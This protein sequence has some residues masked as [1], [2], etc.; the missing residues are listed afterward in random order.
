MNR[1][2]NC[3]NRPISIYSDARECLLVLSNEKG[4]RGIAF[5]WVCY[6]C[7]YML[8][9]Y[10]S[11]FTFW[12]L[13]KAALNERNLY[14]IIV[15][16][17]MGTSGKEDERNLKHFH[18]Q[19]CRGYERSSKKEAFK[20]LWK[21]RVIIMGVAGLHNC[22]LRRVV[23]TDLRVWLERV[24]LLGILKNYIIYIYMK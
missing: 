3:V 16:V 21:A 20:H 23:T 4:L 5:A 19:N 8:W 14:P 18:R 17:N 7:L 10:R 13:I 6:C 15:N 11:F 22:Y 12:F 2:L 9:S 1:K 24:Y